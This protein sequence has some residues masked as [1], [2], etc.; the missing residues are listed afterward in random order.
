M[1]RRAFLKSSVAGP[2]ALGALAAGGVVG[3]SAPQ[4]RPS[5]LTAND[6]QSYVRSLGADWVDPQRTVDTFKAGDPDME[7][8]GIAV[9]WLSY[10]ASLE[11]AV[12]LGCNLFITHEPTYYDHRDADQSVFAF[13]AARKKKAFIEKSGLAVIRCHDV[14]DRVEEIGIGDAWAEFLG[15]TIELPAPGNP[16]FPRSGVY[17][18]LYELPEIEAGRFAREVAQKVSAFGQDAVLLIGPEDKLVRSVAIGVGAITPFR[19]MVHD[20]GADIVICTDD[21]FSFWRDG[22]LAIDMGQPVI[23]VNHPC[24]EEI[25]MQRLAEHLAGRFPQVPVRHVPQRCMFK[26]ISA[27]TLE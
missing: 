24:S 6:V 4:E 8:K 12:E 1:D 15:L 5:P 14:W 27:E 9:G 21:G 7:V 19:Y 23:V 11:K 22:S 3:K 16:R 20:L 26:V 18:G 25:G 17:C 10:L 2:A 13:E